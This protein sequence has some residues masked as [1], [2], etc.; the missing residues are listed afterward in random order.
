[1]LTYL[2]MRSRLMRSQLACDITPAMAMARW[3][4]PTVFTRTAPSRAGKKGLAAPLKPLRPV[5]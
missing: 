1:M 3:A 2:S 5:M 4:S